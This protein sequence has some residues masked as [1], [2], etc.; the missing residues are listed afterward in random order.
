M[1]TEAYRDFVSSLWEKDQRRGFSRGSVTGFGGG[2]GAG[3]GMSYENAFG[4]RGHKKRR[5]NFGYN[6]DLVG[7]TTRFRRH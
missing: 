4:N 5:Y 6:P 2:F 7:T 3:T 1:S